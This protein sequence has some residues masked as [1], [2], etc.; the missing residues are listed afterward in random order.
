MTRTT[1][2]GIGLRA[3]VLLLGI[4]LL[5]VWLI[6]LAFKIASAAIHLVFWLALALI[7]IGAV[8]WLRNR[9]RKR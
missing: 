2:R 1:A 9:W 6:S 8:M 7:V 5:G 3:L 4:I